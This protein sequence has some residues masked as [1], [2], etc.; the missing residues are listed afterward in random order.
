MVQ[1]R[2][3][4][5][6]FISACLIAVKGQTIDPGLCPAGATPTPVDPRWRYSTERFEIITE[7]VA[8]AEVIEIAQAFS[9]ARDSIALNARGSE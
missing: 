3:S 6:L 2:I 8:D 7:L 5:L 4:L 1:L 9:T